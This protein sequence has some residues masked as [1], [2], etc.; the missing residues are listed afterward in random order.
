LSE[1]CSDQTNKTLKMT[2]TDK[3]NS[4]QGKYHKCLIENVTM[5]LTGLLTSKTTNLYK[6]KDDMGRIT[7]IKGLKS[8]SYYQRLIRFFERYSTTGLFLDLLLWALTTVI[9]EADNFF[10]MPQNGKLVLLDYTF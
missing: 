7:G 10:W 2:L 3:L 1:F 6:M 5:L 9:K 8:G 4:I